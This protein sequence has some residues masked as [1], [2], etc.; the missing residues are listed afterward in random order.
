MFLFDCPD[1]CY[2]RLWRFKS[3]KYK[4]KVIIRAEVKEEEKKGEE[5]K[6]KGGRKDIRVRERRERERNC[7]SFYDEFIRIFLIC[8]MITGVFL[9]TFA[10][11]S[12]SSLLSSL[13]QRNAEFTKSL[14]V[15]TQIK[16]DCKIGIKLFN[17][18]KNHLKYGKT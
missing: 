8:L 12:I 4:R 2:G 5:K 9:Y 11:G 1:C 6:R 16:S 13:D 3:S 17:K 7:T 14:N 10:I 15:L 18:V